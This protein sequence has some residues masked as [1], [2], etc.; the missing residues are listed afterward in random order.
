M[1]ATASP[2]AYILEA[3]TYLARPRTFDRSDTVKGVGGSEAN[4]QGV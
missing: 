3:M 4:V 1:A 2:V